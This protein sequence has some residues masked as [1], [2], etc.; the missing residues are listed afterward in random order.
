[1]DYD[2]KAIDDLKIPS[3][4]NEFLNYLKTIKGKS[5]NTIDGYCFDL[6]IFYRFLLMYKHLVDMKAPFNEIYIANVNIDLIKNVTLND[7]YS[8]ISFAENYRGNGTYAKARKIA[9]LKSYFKF[10]HNKVKLIDLNPA[11][12]LESPKIRKA[13][14][15]Y[16]TLE[17]SKSLLN[18]VEGEN[19]ERDFCII[20]FFLNCGMRL[21]ELCGINISKIK[22]DT[23]T[24]LGKGDKE[25]VL[26]LNS[27]CIKALN[28]YLAV[29]A[30]LDDNK[31]LDKDPLFL[32]RQYKRINKRTVELIVEKYLAKAGLT[33]DKYSP[34]KLRHTA[35][36]LMYKYGKVDIRALQRILGHESIATTQIYTH[37]DDEQLREAV[38]LNPLNEE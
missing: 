3:E 4:L 20:T 16:L 8:Y 34:H 24:V 22:A 2:L 30:N 31:I 19:S 6:V 18:S 36:T 15:I 7:L 11:A 9:A 23:I 28:N 10:L 32:S 5:I 27:S 35:A 26:Y 37:L 17:E 29:R 12:E 25:R 33:N 21:S 13:N 1:M 14:P 38:K